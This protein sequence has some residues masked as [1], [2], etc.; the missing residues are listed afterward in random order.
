MFTPRLF[1]PQFTGKP[2]A[3]GFRQRER[4]PCG[5]EWAWSYDLGAGRTSP[6][7]GSALL[8]V[9]RR[10]HARKRAWLSI[11]DDVLEELAAAFAP[12]ETGSRGPD[13]PLYPS[14]WNTERIVLDNLRARVRALGPLPAIR[15]IADEIR[16]SVAESFHMR[17]GDRSQVRVGV[18]MFTGSSWVIPG[19]AGNPYIPSVIRATGREQSKVFD[20]L[21]RDHVSG[22]EHAFDWVYK[23]GKPVLLRAPLSRTWQRRLNGCGVRLPNNGGIC[24]A[25]IQYDRDD[26]LASGL[27]FVSVENPNPQ[28]LAPASVSWRPGSRSRSPAISRSCRARPASPG[29]RT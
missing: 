28:L 7:A 16:S 9:S 27:L 20:Y 12:D 17:L 15:E 25:P 19:G 13:V 2:S 14:L 10:K 24:I 6:A 1:A 22:D 18:Y 8:W 11:K 4:I 5:G 3:R 29:G 23:S 26:A 21:V